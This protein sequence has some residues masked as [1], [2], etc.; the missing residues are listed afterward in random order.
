M[1]IFTDFDI[2]LYFTGDAICV[3]AIITFLHN[4]IFFALY[5][6]CCYVSKFY[7][8]N[9]R[10]TQQNNLILCYD[11]IFVYLQKKYYHHHHHQPFSDP[12][13]GAQAYL[14][15]TRKTG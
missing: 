1:L 2:S 15:D 8:K 6:L 14:M 4:E 12:T 11:T 5:C 7:C 3:G 13:A 10:F 9:I